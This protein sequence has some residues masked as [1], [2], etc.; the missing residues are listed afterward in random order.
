MLTQGFKNTPCAI[1]RRVSEWFL[2]L[3]FLYS[4]AF[5]CFRVTWYRCGFDPLLCINS[6]FYRYKPFHT[7]LW[8]YFLFLLLKWSFGYQLLLFSIYEDLAV[9]YFLF[10]WWGVQSSTLARG[11]SDCV[12]LV[13]Y[14][15]DRPTPWL[16]FQLYGPPLALEPVESWILCTSQSGCM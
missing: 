5:L 6:L 15:W 11:P 9:I 16:W 12:L 14:A 3:K 13:D 8:F 2:V 4:P 7:W 10:Q 1:I